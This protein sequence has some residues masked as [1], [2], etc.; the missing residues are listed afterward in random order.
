[1]TRLEALLIRAALADLI[2]AIDKADR[3]SAARE[4]LP[5]GSTRA[6]VTTANAK[7]S[8]AARHRSS[9]EARFRALVEA[10]P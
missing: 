10:A 4:A 3:A 2:D 1:M 7:W 6:R 9:M 5:P 8:N